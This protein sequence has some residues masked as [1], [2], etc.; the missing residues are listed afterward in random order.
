MSYLQ[1]ETRD[2]YITRS[3]TLS[4]LARV[5][6][7]PGYLANITDQRSSVRTILYLDDDILYL[8]SDKTFFL[9]TV[10]ANNGEYIWIFTSNPNVEPLTLSSIQSTW[11]A[12]TWSW[13]EEWA[14]MRTDNPNRNNLIWPVRSWEE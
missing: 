8:T 6:G 12:I 10:Q 4:I 7:Y 1:V 11:G 5:G 14:N 9:A 2:G 13:R 3:L